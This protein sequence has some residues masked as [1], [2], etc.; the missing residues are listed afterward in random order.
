MA[1]RRRR[2]D[3]S[4]AGNAAG[5]G[6]RHPH[7]WARGQVAEIEVLDDLLQFGVAIAAA[8]PDRL[9]VHGA[10]V[11]RDGGALVLVGRSGQGKSTAATAA[12]IFRR[13]GSARR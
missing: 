11:G 3:R 5:D 9:V 4:R 8:T 12:L 6:P 10:V 7:R 1:R 13:V 2:L